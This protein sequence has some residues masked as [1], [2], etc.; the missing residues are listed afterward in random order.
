[1]CERCAAAWFAAMTSLLIDS[2]MIGQR[3]AQGAT[4]TAAVA[5]HKFTKAAPPE[6]TPLVATPLVAAPVTASPAAMPKA[7]PKIKAKAA[8]ETAPETFT[9]KKCKRQFKQRNARTMHERFCSGA[10]K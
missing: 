1:M 3:F 6:A 10:K 4:A 5:L 7:A 8:P 2:L 9:C